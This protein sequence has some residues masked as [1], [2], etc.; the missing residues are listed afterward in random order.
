MLRSFTPVGVVSFFLVVAACGGTT[1]PGG[2]A[3]NGSGPCSEAE[4]GPPPG[5]GAGLCEDG[6]S[7][8]GPTG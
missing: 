4:C 7:M 8:S 6:V 1:P 5:A 2:T 3:P